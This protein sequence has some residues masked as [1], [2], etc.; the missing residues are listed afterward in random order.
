M[1]ALFKKI[2]DLIATSFLFPL[3]TVV[4]I[5]YGLICLVCKSTKMVVRC[6]VE[7]IIDYEMKKLFE[8]KKEGRLCR[9]IDTIFLIGFDY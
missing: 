7:K 2:I 6:L 5:A 3:L 9:V 4:L 8:G 1:I